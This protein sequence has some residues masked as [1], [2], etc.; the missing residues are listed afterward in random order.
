M[1]NI[2]TQFGES[3]MA[4]FEENTWTFELPEGFKVKAGSFAIV[5]E[6]QYEKLITALRGIRNSVNVHPD[7]E[8]DSEFETMVSRCDEILKQLE[9]K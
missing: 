9:T 7:C 6:D 5:P 4:D 2:T 3:L 8:P 1:E